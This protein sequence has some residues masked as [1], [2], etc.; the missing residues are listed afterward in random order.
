MLAE[1]TVNPRHLS[2]LTVHGNMDSIGAPKPVGPFKD[3][4]NMP[5]PTEPDNADPLLESARELSETERH[6]NQL[7]VALLAIGTTVLGATL[8]VY[9]TAAEVSIQHN[10]PRQIQ[11]AAI[12]FAI[13]VYIFGFAITLKTLFL[14]P[15]KKGTPRL[16][17]RRNM[18]MS[19][20][21]WFGVLALIAAVVIILQIFTSD[22][23]RNHTNRGTY[24][25]EEHR[26]GH[27]PREIGTDPERALGEEERHGGKE[28]EDESPNTEEPIPS[29]K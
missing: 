18:A 25:V 4:S 23:A 1:R 11:S 5:Y 14:L 6:W 21:A 9:G 3:G 16:T 10:L 20:V 29:L 19:A 27:R 15:T 24:P 13:A 17:Q 2:A 22:T 12:V 7:V 8:V 26:D 28:S